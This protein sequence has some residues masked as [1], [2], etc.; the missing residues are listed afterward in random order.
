MYIMYVLHIGS[1]NDSSD[2]SVGGSELPKVNEEKCLGVTIR[3]DLKL[4]KH[5]SE[6]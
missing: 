4:G 1:N 3:N 2:Y 6:S 5:C